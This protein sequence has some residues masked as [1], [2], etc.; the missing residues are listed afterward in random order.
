MPILLIRKYW[1]LR[2][3][4]STM[5]PFHSSLVWHFSYLDL[6]YQK[7]LS[8]QTFLISATKAVFRQLRHDTCVVSWQQSTPIAQRS[9]VHTADVPHRVGDDPDLDRLT[10]GAAFTVHSSCS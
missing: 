4:I 6:Y 2:R 9:V 7:R 8:R 3:Y 1:H 10:T 5:L